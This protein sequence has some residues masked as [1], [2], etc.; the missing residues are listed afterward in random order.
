MNNGVPAGTK[1]RLDKR[2]AQ[3]RLQSVIETTDIRCGNILNKNIEAIIDECTTTQC[4]KSNHRIC[5]P[6]M[7]RDIIW[8]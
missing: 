8:L 5:K 2:K 4:I 7:T 1:R 3:A 6:Y